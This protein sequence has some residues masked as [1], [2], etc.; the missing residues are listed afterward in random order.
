[1]L[2]LYAAILEPDI[3]QVM[4][5]EPPT[6]HA[7]GPIFLDILRY[8]DLPEAAALIAPSHLTFFARVP[9]EFDYTRHVYTLYGKPGNFFRAMDIHQVLEGRYDHNFAPGL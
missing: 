7:V 2:G 6:T 1:M 3:Q 8:T 9:R 4:L 5:M